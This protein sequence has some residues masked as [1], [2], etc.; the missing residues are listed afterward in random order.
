[1]EKEYLLLY[2][3]NI[4]RFRLK[5]KTGFINV[6]AHKAESARKKAERFLPEG[7]WLIPG[8]IYIKYKK[9]VV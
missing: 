6:T 5:V 9:R 3:V 2:K 8:E 7:A 1:M 4:G